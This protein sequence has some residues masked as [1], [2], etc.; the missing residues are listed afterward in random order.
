MDTVKTGSLMTQ[1]RAH[2][3]CQVFYKLNYERYWQRFCS[4]AVVTAWGT[5]SERAVCYTAV[6]KVG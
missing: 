6:S 1:C 3:T 5:A 2:G 4:V